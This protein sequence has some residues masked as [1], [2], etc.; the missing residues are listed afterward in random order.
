MTRP[1][2]AASRSDEDDILQEIQ[3]GRNESSRRELSTIT[4]QF[5]QPP[6]AERR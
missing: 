3:K 5:C 4:G 6:M 2:V 1:M